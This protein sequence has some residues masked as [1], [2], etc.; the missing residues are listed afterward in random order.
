MENNMIHLITVPLQPLGLIWHLIS[1]LYSLLFE[2]S[3]LLGT[4]HNHSIAFQPTFST[5]PFLLCGLNTITYLS[6][7]SLLVS[8]LG[9]SSIKLASMIR[10]CQMHNLSL[11]SYKAFQLMETGKHKLSRITSLT[12]HGFNH[13]NK[14]PSQQSLD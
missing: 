14:I 5:F 3:S 9:I 2:T 6:R 4:A 8:P 13:I 10:S 12:N 1:L 11:S 7:F